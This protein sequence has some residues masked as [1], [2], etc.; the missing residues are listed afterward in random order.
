MIQ[1]PKDQYVLHY[2]QTKK[3]QKGGVLN[4]ALKYGMGVYKI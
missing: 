2:F 4:L 3:L 1:Y